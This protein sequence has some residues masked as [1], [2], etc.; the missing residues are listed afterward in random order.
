MAEAQSGPC[1]IL[2]ASEHESCQL[3]LIL[4]PYCTVRS[5]AFILR[6]TAEINTSLQ[7]FHQDV[8]FWPINSLLTMVNFANPSGSTTPSDSPN[9][10]NASFPTSSQAHTVPPFSSPQSLS[11]LQSQ[12]DHNDS[13]GASQPPQIIVIITRYDYFGNIKEATEQLA[14]PR[15]HFARKTYAVR[16]QCPLSLSIYAHSTVCSLRTIVR[17]Y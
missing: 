1:H 8:I 2:T 9:A 5:A 11:P 7:L 10:Y 6:L 4:D 3:W 15:S 13:A 12:G 17:A 16:T 14:F